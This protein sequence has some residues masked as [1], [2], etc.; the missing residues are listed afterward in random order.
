MPASAIVAFTN[1]FRLVLRDERDQ[2]SPTLEQINESAYDY[3]KLHRI[4]TSLDIGLPHPFCLHVS[5]DGSILLPK[6]EKLWPVENAVSCVNQVLGEIVLGGIYFDAVLPT[7]IDQG[8]LYDTGYFR[9]HGLAAS[10]TAQLHLAL[11][12][13]MASTLHSILLHEPH[14]VLARELVEAHQ[15]G[16]TISSKIG[17]LRVEFV[18]QGISAFLSHDWASALSHFWIAIEQLISFMWHERVV[19]GPTQPSAPIEGRAQFLDDY[20]TWVTSARVEVLYQLRALP[21]ETYRLLNTARK[22]RNDLAHSGVTPRKVAAEAAFDA[23]FQL[24]S[25]IHTPNRIDSLGAIVARLKEFDSVQRHYKPR[26]PV[27][28]VEGALWLGPL[29][30]VPG[31]KEWG[32]RDL[33]RVVRDASAE[34]T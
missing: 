6:I 19:A 15:R 3:V 5:F 33:E 27:K 26:E 30:P 23:A 7:D 17:T 20:R 34:P 14:H 16:A 2:W 31:E 32:N 29:P 13:K 11:Q 4:S 1:P 10:L 24:I 22:A 18:L 28:G 9:A 12:C 25:G 21:E 8:V